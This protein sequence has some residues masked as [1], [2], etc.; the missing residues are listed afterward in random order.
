MLEASGMVE[1]VASAER[2]AADEL[3]D[4]LRWGVYVVFE[5]PNAYA[6]ACFAE[7]GLRT[8]ASGRFAALWRPYHLI[9][10]ELGVSAVQAVLRGE[11]T[12]ATR[13]WA[14]D[15]VAVAKRDLPA[16]ETLDGEG[17][18]C[19]WG[20]LVLAAR[21]LDLRALPIGLAH[22]VRLRR[23]V[24]HGA[25]ITRDDVE[26]PVSSHRGLLP[27][28]WRLPHA[29]WSRGRAAASASAE[30]QG[31][32]TGAFARS[33]RRAFGRRGT[34]RSCTVRIG[35]SGRVSGSVACRRSSRRRPVMAGS[36]SSPACTAAATASSGSRAVRRRG[37]D[38]VGRAAGRCR[39]RPRPSPTPGAGRRGGP[40]GRARHRPSPRRSPALS[41]VSAD[42]RHPRPARAARV[43]PSRRTGSSAACGASG[44]SLQRRRRARVRDE[45]PLAASAA[46][47]GACARGRRPAASR[48][49]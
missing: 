5:A 46:G 12:G 19:A 29:G 16:G 37:L 15:V 13:D 6:R 18:R 24:A 44:A 43:S 45:A 11:P 38:A 8:D 41:A 39:T 17:G 30:A 47:G 4:H 42:A 22:G 1:V 40:R 36:P 9:G 20:K 48:R 2:G 25:V 32:R 34:V 27:H 28:G 14:G 23:P 31:P 3:P 33:R 35:V 10:L 49:A 21:S 7:Y 26:T